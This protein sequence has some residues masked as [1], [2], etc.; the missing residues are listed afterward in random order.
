M[1]LRTLL[2][3]DEH[4]S[5]ARSLCDALTSWRIVVTTDR[6]SALRVVQ[7]HKPPVAVV[8]FALSP[9]AEE[10]PGAPVLLAG[11]LGEAPE[12]KVIMLGGEDRAQAVRAIMHGAHDV[13]RPRDN[14]QELALLIER[15]HHR[16]ELEA[17]SRR[18][19]GEAPATLRAVRD[20]AERRAVA[21]ALARA[22]GNLSA[23]ARLLEVSRPTLYNL[24]RQH[25]IR[26]TDS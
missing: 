24:I 17:E 21:D 3:V 5:L 19:A 18:V 4:P 15:A 22:N 12:T 6:E 25:G 14:A 8:S 16:H 2:L 11:I 23:A 9:E 26:A 13:Y 1:A 10:P 20:A 7:V